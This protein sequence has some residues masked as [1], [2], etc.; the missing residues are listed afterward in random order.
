MVAA[1]YAPAGEYVPTAD[2]R[3]V[4]AGATWEHYELEL[5]MR[6]EKSVPRL[7]Y[8]EGALELMSP[9]R[10]HEQI[11]SYL[12][13]LIEVYAEHNDIELSPYRSWTLKNAAPPVA[14][15]TSATSWAPTSRRT[16]SISPSR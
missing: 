4:L 2:Q 10:H 15:P 11:T 16:A 12:G 8:L 13:R 5:A 1:A 9:S 14:S 3:V 6:G 7:A